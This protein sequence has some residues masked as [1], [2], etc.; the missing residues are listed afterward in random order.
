MDKNNCMAKMMEKELE[1]NTR[2]IKESA[3][4]IRA[5]RH[6]L[7]KELLQLIHT[8]GRMT[9]SEMYHK[10]NI[11]QSVTS[12]HLGALRQAGFVHTERNGKNIFY[13]VN[14]A[15]LKHVHGIVDKLIGK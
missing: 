12:Q 6:N 15:Q 11:E 13:S 3:Q 2:G 10:L 1:I 4:V 7:R 9:V 5:I 14:Y 8:H